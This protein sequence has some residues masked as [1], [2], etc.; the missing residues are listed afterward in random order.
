MAY[1]GVNDVEMRQGVLYRAALELS[2]RA[3]E[4]VDWTEGCWFYFDED[5]LG[6]RVGIQSIRARA[7][8]EKIGR[9]VFRNFV[10]HHFDYDNGVVWARFGY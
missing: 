1:A 7:V 6:V 4:F 9:E 10:P 3:D 5:R 2:Q 8:I